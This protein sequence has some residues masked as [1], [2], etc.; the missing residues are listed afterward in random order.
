MCLACRALWWTNS[1]QLNS[2]SR[3]DRWRFCLFC[4]CFLAQNVTAEEEV[5][6]RFGLK[7]SIYKAMHPLICQYVG[8]MEAEVQPLPDG[9]A[10]VTFMLQSG[11]HEQFGTVTAHWQRIGDLFL[12]TSSVRLRD[13]A[14]ILSSVNDNSSNSNGNDE[15]VL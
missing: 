9:T 3:I 10:E 6:L 8:F 12:S 15:C 4:L 1:T 5:L 2:Q 11:V 13:D 14:P 7:E